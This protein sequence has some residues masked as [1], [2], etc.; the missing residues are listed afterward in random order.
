M[1]VEGIFQKHNTHSDE[2]QTTDTVVAQSGCGDVSRIKAYL[3]RG[4]L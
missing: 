1:P 2:H 4:D 3:T